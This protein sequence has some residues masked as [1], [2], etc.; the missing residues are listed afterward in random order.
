M[1]PVL[2]AAAAP[3]EYGV[4]VYF[5]RTDQTPGAPSPEFDVL[6]HKAAERMATG[7]GFPEE[8]VSFL[9]MQN[10]SLSKNDKSLALARI[11][12]TLAFTTVTKQMRR[13]L[14]CCRSEAR[15]DALIA[16]DA[17]SFSNEGS[18]DA[19]WIAHR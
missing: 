14:G 16:A 5:K 18:E 1:P 6:R 10:V 4:L 12:G 17:N 9:C 15:L 7:G 13:L 11:Q 19:A 2:A 8:F 3:C